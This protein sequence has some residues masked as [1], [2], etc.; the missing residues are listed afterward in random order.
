MGR[1][2]S[3]EKGSYPGLA[4]WMEWLFWRKL[5]V[6]PDWGCE[7]DGQ[8]WFEFLRIRSLV[9]WWYNF[10]GRIASKFHKMNCPKCAGR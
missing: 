6:R 3:D 5:C 8:K 2:Y 9:G 4:G 7:W 10:T 1:G